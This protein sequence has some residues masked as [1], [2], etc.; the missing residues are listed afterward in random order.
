MNDVLIRTGTSSVEKAILSTPLPGLS[1]ATLSGYLSDLKGYLAFARQRSLSPG[2]V[3]TL[4]DYR[5]YLLIDRAL[6]P[7]T[8]NRNLMAVKRSL[9]EYARREYTSG[10]VEVLRGAYREVKLVKLA[11]GEKHVSRDK[12]I[13]KEE[14]R[15]LLAA[16]PRRVGLIAEFLF[17]TGAR[18]SEAIGVKLSDI[19]NV[20]GYSE[21]VVLGKGAKART[22]LVKTELLDRCARCYAGTVHLFETRNGTP[23][24]RSYVFREFLRASKR[25]LGKRVTPHCARHSFATWTLDR[26]KKVKGVSEYLGHSDV[27]TTLN[28]YVHEK[29]EA[30]EL[31]EEAALL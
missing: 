3:S 15:A 18:V 4:V 19:K 22:L 6:R 31:L 23:Y 17:Q 13:T 10:K 1:K 21:I 24:A 26:T 27:S 20:N 25:V 5:R 7:A 29:L 9:L 28:L 14:A 16:M 12:L 11:S 8:V 30:G 2:D